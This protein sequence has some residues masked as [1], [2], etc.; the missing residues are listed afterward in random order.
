MIN[1]YILSATLQ[2]RVTN[3]LE[4]CAI[5]LPD[6]SGIIF[7]PPNVVNMQVDKKNEGA[8]DTVVAICQLS[9]SGNPDLLIINNNS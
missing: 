6:E 2:T 5:S 3:H 9:K 1:V 7:C 8:L 4:G